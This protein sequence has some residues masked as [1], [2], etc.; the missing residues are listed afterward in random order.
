LRRCLVLLA[1]G[2]PA[3]FCALSTKPIFLLKNR[4]TPPSLGRGPF[5]LLAAFIY[6]GSLD[7]TPAGARPV[8]R[9]PGTP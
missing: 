7:N 1:A 3:Y 2:F 9:E 5:G 4:P 8:G 6:R